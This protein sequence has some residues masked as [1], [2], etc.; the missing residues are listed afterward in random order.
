MVD[1]NFG[2]SI[3][4][5]DELKTLNNSLNKI[6]QVRETNHIMSLIIN[7]LIRSTS[8][9]QGLINLVENLQGEELTTVVRNSGR[10]T[11][12]LPYK[13]NNQI[14][15]WV[16]TNR[17]LLKI[18]SLN[19]DD[20]F[21]HLSSEDASVHSI[22]C[23]PMIAR[24][25]IIGL[26]TLVRDKNKS[27]FTEKDS[28]LTGILTSQ[29]ANILSNAILLERLARNCELLELSQKKLK[30]ENALLR[31][32]PNRQFQF[33]NIIGKSPSIRNALTLV[34][35]F[36]GHNSPVLITGDTGTG[37][38]LF[39]K[40]IHLASERM[41]NQFVVK[42]CSVKTESLLESELFG[43]TKGSFTGAIKDKIGLFKE[44][45]GG[46][47]FLDEIADAPLTTQAAIL[48]VIQNGEIRPIGASKT[49]YVNVR[50][51]SATN[52]DL[53][54]LI[55]KSEFREDLYYRLNTFIIELPSL[56]QRRDDIPLL[57]AYFLNKLKIT[58]GK[59]NLTISAA[60]MDCLMK[61]TWPGNVRQLEHELERAAVI[62][63]SDCRID[64]EHLSI[65]ISCAEMNTEIK[66][67]YHGKLR[68]I[69]ERIEKQVICATLK[70]YKGN[71]LQVSKVLGLTR[72][73]LKDKITRY[74]ITEYKDSTR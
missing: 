53:K 3:T 51:I 72:K 29:S 12:G 9:D 13:L 61:Y 45:D 44:A 67:G 32:Q 21:R 11:G 71:I 63:D 64:S 35:K 73:G 54:E 26:V 49:E 55:K 2:E 4:P 18:D 69:V 23:C 50:I 10:E 20:R 40:A 27:P 70:E 43:H 15:G 28:R 42:N 68:D 59:E 39:A 31:K 57:I 5:F 52:K 66:P 74:Q 30:E 38:D 56:C 62:C 46:T 16:L 19:S 34:S 37:K 6:C 8:A 47:I 36:G 65:E 17:Q 25:E 60:A 41:N 48:R 1:E 24:G 22:I 58:T 7:E 14:S 33:E